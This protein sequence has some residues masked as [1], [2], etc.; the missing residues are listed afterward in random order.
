MKNLMLA[1]IVLGFVSGPAMASKS[2]RRQAKISACEGKE[3]GSTCSFEGRRGSV[4]GVCKEGRRNPDVLK[5]VNP[6]RK[7]RNKKS[8]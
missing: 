2:E 3:Q 6:N 4:E 8:N 1:T 5:C 7:K